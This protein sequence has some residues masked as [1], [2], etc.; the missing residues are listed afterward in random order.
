[1]SDKPSD[2]RAQAAE[3]RRREDEQRRRDDVD[4]RR[5]AGSRPALEDGRAME[6]ST[7]G[8]RPA[9]GSADDREKR[10]DQ[11]QREREDRSRAGAGRRSR[12][13]MREDQEEDQGLDAKGDHPRLTPAEIAAHW[14]EVA[15]KR[16]ND[17]RQVATAANRVI[18]T[19]QDG[20]TIED[21]GSRIR[22][23]GTM[24]AE[25]AD[26]MMDAASRHGWQEV[27]VTGSAA[28]KEMLARAALRAGL[29]VANPEL[30]DKLDQW[31][32]EEIRAQDRRS[33]DQVVRDMLREMRIEREGVPATPDEFRQALATW[34]A[35]MASP[36]SSEWDR[37]YTQV[38]VLDTA[39]SLVSDRAQFRAAHEQGVAD[40]AGRWAFEARESE[41]RAGM[42]DRG[43]APQTHQ[44]SASGTEA[45]DTRTDAQRL[46]D[47]MDQQRAE[48]KERGEIPATRFGEA[49][50]DYR[51][52][53]ADPRS[54]AADREEAKVRLL[55]SAEAAT[56]T[57]TG[58]QAASRF[59]RRDLDQWAEEASRITET[60]RSDD[61]S[62]T[63]AAGHATTA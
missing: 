44:P 16:P 2:N 30:R 48:W 58:W 19:M 23:R 6:M 9:R 41:R 59:G 7:R 47:R 63:H 34:R 25:K 13:T 14:R 40:E 46:R 56:A 21:D 31:R 3:R 24:T 35:D 29:E 45:A 62:P 28:E 33:H 53:M 11:M 27:R 32:A 38:R 17:L 39:S 36:T 61:Q 52:A 37:L 20:D 18:V 51:V 54:S 55:V 5:S 15:G 22:L 26:A 1:M 57:E 10:L 4:E 43:A 49:L 60:A 50:D 12:A 42:Q 8:N